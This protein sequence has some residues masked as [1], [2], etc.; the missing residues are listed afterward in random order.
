MSG[1][2]E[3]RRLSGKPLQQF[4]HNKDEEMEVGGQGINQMRAVNA[5]RKLAGRLCVATL[6][7]QRHCSGDE[8]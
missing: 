8:Y 4:D 1:L 7:L 2:R 6:Y 3:N 5:E